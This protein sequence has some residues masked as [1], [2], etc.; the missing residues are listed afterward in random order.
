LLKIQELWEYFF[1]RLPNTLPD[2]STLDSFSF[3]AHYNKLT[4]DTI[5][6]KISDLD[7]NETLELCIEGDKLL[8][9][10]LIRDD[11]EVTTSNFLKKI[12]NNS[13]IKEIL[14]RESMIEDNLICY[15]GS[16]NEHQSFE[17]AKS[18]KVRTLPVAYM[19][20]NVGS[21]SSNFSSLSI[22][23]KIPLKTVNLFKSRLA[24]EID[25]FKPELVLRRLEKNELNFSRQIKKL[26][27]DA[28][29][30]SLKKDQLKKQQQEEAQRRQ[31]EIA[32]LA[33]RKELNE[34]LFLIHVNKGY[35]E[36]SLEGL[37]KGETTNIRIK[38]SNGNS[39][40]EKFSNDDTL[41][42]LYSIVQLKIHLD[43]LS[44]ESLKEFHSE[45]STV[46]A[47]LDDGYIHDFKFELISPF[48]RFTVPVENGTLIKDVAQLWPNG[49]LLVEFNEDDDEEE[50]EDV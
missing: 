43:S 42:N 36:R 33:R 14:Q 5:D 49:S 38:L 12:I 4:K 6:F 20:G 45:A 32:D 27:D 11:D 40:T 8:L 46:H 22:L 9:L 30:E 37:A 41:L 26:Q 10:I 25:R 31:K 16:V 13:A 17:I 47:P 29:E 35:N 28:F 48:P 7:Y 1:P 19:I 18:L 34:K 44:E 2:E 3:E 39:I 50:E 21:A 15:V 23:A 24:R